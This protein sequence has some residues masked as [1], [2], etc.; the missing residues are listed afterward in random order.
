MVEFKHK[1]VFLSLGSNLG[2]KNDNIINAMR[3]IQKNVG[4]ITAKSSFYTSQAVGFESKSDFVNNAICISTQMSIT[5]LLE[6][7]QNIERKLGRER[8]TANEEYTDRVIDIDI[9]YFE[10]ESKEDLD[11]CIPHPRRLDRLFVLIPL[12]EISPDFVDPVINES[13]KSILD[14]RK[15]NLSNQAIY[16]LD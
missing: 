14:K 4:E 2:D 9:I 8:K 1:K 3:L 12:V 13:L 6:A 10:N 15:S 5:E 16:K 11:L 7:L